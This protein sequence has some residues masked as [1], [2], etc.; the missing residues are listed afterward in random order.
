VQVLGQDEVLFTRDAHRRTIADGEYDKLNDWAP[1]RLTPNISFQDFSISAFAIRGRAQL[2]T[3][4]AFGVRGAVEGHRHPK[5]ANLRFFLEFVGDP[6][7]NRPW[8][9]AM[10]AHGSLFCLL[11]GR[12]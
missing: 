10:R 2:Q 7:A 9:R 11:T 8:S 12:F 1:F 5:R 6:E 4:A 3:P